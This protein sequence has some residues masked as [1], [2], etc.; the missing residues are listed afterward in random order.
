MNKILKWLAIVL[1]VA[2]LLL[3]LFLGWS[4]YA[5]RVDGIFIKYV[6]SKVGN[7]SPTS[8]AKRPNT[9]NRAVITEKGQEPVWLNGGYRGMYGASGKLPFVNFH[10]ESSPKDSFEA[11]RITIEKQYTL[12]ASQTK[13][14]SFNK[15]IYKDHTYFIEGDPNSENSGV[16]EN[17]TVFFP[18]DSILITMYF[19]N[20][21]PNKEKWD[22]NS[23][24]EYKSLR[25]KF[26]QEYVDSVLSYKSS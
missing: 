6:P 4:G 13:T 25:D 23:S 9:N 14:E 20:Q 8:M 22:Y 5:N 16:R 3:I 24:E 15:R 11:N 17:V 19:L 12:A 7:F 1:G 18:E 2:F 26:I 10:A 21:G